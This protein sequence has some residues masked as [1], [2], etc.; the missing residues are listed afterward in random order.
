MKTCDVISAANMAI[1]FFSKSIHNWLVVALSLYVA[2]HHVSKCFTKMTIRFKSVFISISS[3]CPWARH[4]SKA[5]IPKLLPGRRS[6]NGCPLLRVCVHCCACAL[7][8]VKCRALIPSMG[9]HTWPYVTSLSLFNSTDFNSVTQ[10]LWIS[11][12][13]NIEKKSIPLS[14]RILCSNKCF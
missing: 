6:I 14:T 9:H 3:T 4:R 8:W 11:Y 7:W 13:E 5:R 1:R 12:L 10:N 2:I